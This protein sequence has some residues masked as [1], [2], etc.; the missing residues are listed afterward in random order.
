M[1]LHHIHFHF[2]QSYMALLNAFAII[3]E[4]KS[5]GTQKVQLEIRV[6]C[7]CVE[8]RIDFIRVSFD[9]NERNP[10]LV[11]RESLNKLWQLIPIWIQSLEFQL[12]ITIHLIQKQVLLWLKW[13]SIKVF[14]NSTWTL[15]SFK[16]HFELECSL[17]GTVFFL[18]TYNFPK[19]ANLILMVA[20]FELIQLGK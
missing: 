5:C 16:C 17:N 7:S 11:Q 13:N 15:L 12:I 8:I 6:D 9:W 20:Y 18:R 14:R 19:T 4:L 10:F 2:N 1:S 3:R